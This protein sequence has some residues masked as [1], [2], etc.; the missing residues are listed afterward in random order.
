MPPPTARARE[1]WRSCLWRSLP[2]PHR[3]GDPDRGRVAERA[4]GGAAPGG[5]E[6]HV[7]RLVFLEGEAAPGRVELVRR[8]AQVEEYSGGRTDAGLAG[9][10]SD[11]PEASVAEGHPLAEA[12]EPLARARERLG[13]GIQPEEPR[14]RAPCFQ[15]PFRVSA[16]ADRPVHHPAPSSGAQEKRHFVGQHREVLHLPLHVYTPLSASFCSTSSMGA[17]TLSRSKCVHRSA[18]Q[19]SNF[20]C[21]PMIVTSL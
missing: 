1:A 12:R 5:I 4:G 21:M 17:P 20:S 10:A 16:H 7:E 11:L 15:H 13:V 3:A 2:P 19:I 8:E 18:F 9:V 14:A 6:T